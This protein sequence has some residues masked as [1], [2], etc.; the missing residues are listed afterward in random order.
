MQRGAHTP[1]QVTFN[2]REHSIWRDHFAAIVDTPNL[3]YL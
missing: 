2:L 1:N 3:G